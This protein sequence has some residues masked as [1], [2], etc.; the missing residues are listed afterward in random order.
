MYFISYWSNRV[1]PKWVPWSAVD[2]Q[3]EKF[4]LSFSN[5]PG[6]IKPFSWKFKDS[7]TESYSCIASKT[8]MLVAGKI[9]FNVACT[10]FCNSF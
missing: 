5:T 3:S 6:P 9:G 1:C 7:N 10:S 8:Y 2:I 4:T